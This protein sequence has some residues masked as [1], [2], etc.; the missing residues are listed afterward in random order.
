MNISQQIKTHR[1]EIGLTQEQLA[2]Y[3]GVSA[4]AVNKWEKG[5][6]YPDVTLLP[7]IARLLKIDMNEL[8]SFRE[9]LTELE[10]AIFSN[11]LSEVALNESIAAAFEMAEQKIREYPHCGSMLY[12]AAAILNG[13]LTLSQAHGVQ[14]NEYDGKI[15]AWFERSADSGDEKLRLS[16]L[17]MLASKYI[18]MQNFDKASLL[19]REIPDID[20]DKAMLQVTIL[21]K[22]ED[23][24]AAAV[25]LEGKLIQN[26]IRL[27]AYLNKLLELEEQSG[28]SDKADQ[29]AEIAGEMT[30]L[31]GLWSYGAVVPHLSLSI[32][33]KDESQSLSLIKAALIEA[34]KPWNVEASPLYY[35]IPAKKNFKNVGESFI[36]AIISEI[37]TQDEYA[38]LR[39]N[40]ALEKILSEYRQPNG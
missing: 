34:Q 28:N 4:P 23:A 13:A 35:R 30:R 17:Y 24:A 26:L 39:G 29:I 16:A 33:R 11:K 8:F 15:I 36:N 1:K 40:K 14:K 31:F 25:Y 3:L 12:M 20:L 6:T 9:E 38:F 7:A 10:I 37:E 32:Y 22:E 2:N 18:Q 21:S 27:Q 19:L 5:S